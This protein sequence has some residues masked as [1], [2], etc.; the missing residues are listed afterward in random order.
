MKK[1]ALALFIVVMISA[2]TPENQKAAMLILKA[3][4]L[5]I[6]LGM[7]IWFACRRGR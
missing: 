7:T 2:Q 6:L 4:G 5:V 3:I 1:I